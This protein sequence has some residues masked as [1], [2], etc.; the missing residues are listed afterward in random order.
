M[1]QSKQFDMYSMG[2][3]L[4]RRNF[5]KW[6]DRDW[7]GKKF[8]FKDGVNGTYQGDGLIVV[9]F[10]NGSMEA[11]SL[12]GRWFDEVTRIYNGKTLVAE[13]GRRGTLLTTGKG[14]RNGRR[15]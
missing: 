10:S 12:K 14:L 4:N 1:T 7:R 13:R 9:R 11:R 6:K 5:S 8:H 2:F 3:A 15:N